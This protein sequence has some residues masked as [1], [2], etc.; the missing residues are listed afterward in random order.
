MAPQK[1]AHQERGGMA[2]GRPH[3]SQIRE[4]APSAAGCEECPRVTKLETLMVSPFVFLAV[5]W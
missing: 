4:V 5:T 2:N 3:L 1:K